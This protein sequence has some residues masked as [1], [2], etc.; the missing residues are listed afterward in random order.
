MKEPNI[1]G[2]IAAPIGNYY[3]TPKVYREGDK[4][5]FHIG[6]QGGT[7]RI[8]ISHQFYQMFLYEFALSPTVEYIDFEF[9]D[10]EGEEWDT[11]L[12]ILLDRVVN[13]TMRKLLLEIPQSHPGVE[14]LVECMR[15]LREL[16][17]I[18]PPDP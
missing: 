1:Q 6:D 3:G 7:R 9:P 5:W 4:F 2:L 13:V 16:S 17:L 18:F 8:P 14:T 10:L 11:D 15:R 12:K